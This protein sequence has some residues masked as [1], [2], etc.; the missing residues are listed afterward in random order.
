MT[1]ENLVKQELAACEKFLIEET[2]GDV[3]PEDEDHQEEANRI[4]QAK[5][6]YTNAMDMSD[7]EQLCWAVGRVE[8][9]RDLLETFERQ[10]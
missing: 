1:F 8:A 3:Y 2:S 6:D 5:I 9:L 4:I 7:D 10:K